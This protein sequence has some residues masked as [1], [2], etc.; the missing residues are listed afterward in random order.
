MLIA[1]E[2]PLVGSYFKAILDYLKDDKITDFRTSFVQSRGLRTE[3]LN[4]YDVVCLINNSAPDEVTWKKLHSFVTA[5]GGLAIFLG[6]NNSASIDNAKGDRIDPVFYNSKSAMEVMPAS[7]NAVLPF[8]PAETIDFR[9]VQHTLIRRL[10][11]LGALTEL[12][13][14]SIQRH[15]KVT[16]N[17]NGIVVAKYGDK[18]GAPALLERRIGQGRVIL[19]TTSVDKADI[20]EWNDFLQ[21]PWFWVFADQMTQYLSQQASQTCNY[22]VGSEVSL[23]LDRLRKPKQVIVRM[24]DFKQRTQ[25]IRPEAT[26]LFFR[27]LVSA[28]NYQVDSVRGDVE[29]QSGFSLNMPSRESDLRRIER[30]DLDSLLGEGRFSIN[31][32]P[33]SLER[34]VQTGRLGQE[35]YGMVLALLIVVFAL[36]QFTATW[37][38]RSDET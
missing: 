21:N 14:I 6:A 1:A 22:E 18:R 13:A 9:N 2:T 26:S 30:T 8:A 38:Y 17:E 35:A 10:D 29:Y 28:G 19:L 33:S 36:E 4:Q 24:P 15:W 16:P 25:E 23:S 20:V 7:L 34:N 37:F 27:D 12:G 32:D 11:E 31:R 5:G 3:D